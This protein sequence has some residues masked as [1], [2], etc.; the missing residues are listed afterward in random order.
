MGNSE[1]DLRY[2]GALTEDILRWDGFV[3]RI[4]DRRT[5]YGPNPS[6]TDPPPDSVPHD[7]IVDGA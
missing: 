2:F 7:A 3:L 5:G 4:N 1:K 6:M